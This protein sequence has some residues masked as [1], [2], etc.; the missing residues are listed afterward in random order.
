MNYRY[1]KGNFDCTI[2][3]LSSDF[4]QPI[5]KIWDFYHQKNWKCPYDVITVSNKKK[6]ESKNIECI[7]TGV[8]WDENASHF[9]PMVL[10]GLKK[11]KTK[12][13]LF[14]VED[15]IIVNRVENDNIYHALNFMENN[16]ITKLRCLSMPEPDLPLE[17]DPQGPINDENFGTI[18][19]DNEYRN[20]L[21]AAIWNKD[22]FIELLNSKDEDFSGWV[23]E[24]DKDFREYSKKWK[25]VA[26]RQGKGG[27]LLSRNEGQTDS[28]LIQYVE[29]VRWGKLDHIYYDYFMDMFKKDKIDISSKEY[30]PFG[31]NLTK[32]ELPQ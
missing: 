10:E 9:K 4:Y 24:T 30:E 1:M 27:T 13:V 26:C 25:Y 17:G 7:V 2:L 15:Q 19:K 12:Y 6:Y 23:L 29:L 3:V 18:S 32:E 21:Q 5:L 16:D 11:V 20:S 22:R 8:P 28:P 14:M 31:G